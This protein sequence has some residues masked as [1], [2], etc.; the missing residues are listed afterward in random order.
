MPTARQAA[1][2]LAG[3]VT[4]GVG[5]G[6]LLTADLGS[7][8]FSTMINGVT[9]SVGSPFWAVNLVVGVVFVLAAAARG[10]RPGP[11]TVVQVVLVGVTVSVVLAATSTP[12]GLVSR[13]VLLVLAIPALSL[14]RDCPSHPVR[15]TSSTSDLR[16][17]PQHSSTR[18]IILYTRDLTT[19]IYANAPLGLN[20][21]TSAWQRT[22]QAHKATKISP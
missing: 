15:T 19:T 20:R 22:P 9:R 6:M 14:S 21:K 12:D 17:K 3:C 8:G 4:L 1:L 13:G 11:G 7:D 16:H 2:L 10:V 5:V 18:S